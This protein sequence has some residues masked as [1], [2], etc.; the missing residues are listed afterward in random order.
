MVR[1]PNP[2]VRAA[3]RRAGAVVFAADGYE[4][5]TMAA[6]A[7][8]AGVST[9]NIYRYFSNKAGLFDAIFTDA[10]AAEFL[11]R[12]ERRV[13]DLVDADALTRLGAEAQGSEAD[14]L[15]FWIEHR[16]E[17]IT[18]FARAE[19]SSQAG[20][21]ARFLEVLM[22]RT[23][24]DLEARAGRSLGPEAALVLET[25]FDNTVRM[26]VRILEVHEDPDAVRRAFAAF[27][28][29]QLA[30]LAGLREWVTR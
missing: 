17:V 15:G 23:R 11:E 5:A 12:L 21:R 8:E 1:T 3:V 14:L 4:G 10:F 29:Y 28:A 9:G 16:L 7:A 2:E 24:A 26:V 20:F 27:W 13:S 22:A 18:L 25:L 19:G 30:G 6:I